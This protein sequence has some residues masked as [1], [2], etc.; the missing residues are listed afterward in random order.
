[1]LRGKSERV[2]TSLLGASRERGCCMH[3][4]YLFPACNLICNF[5]V[6][7]LCLLGTFIYWFW[8]FFFSPPPLQWC[9]GQRL[10]AA[11]SQLEHRTLVLDIAGE[12]DRPAW[13]PWSSWGSRR[14]AQVISPLGLQRCSVYWVKDGSWLCRCLVV[15]PEPG[16]SW[17]S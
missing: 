16:G 5:P 1:M 6:V 2:G 9:Q 14:S 3:H 7:E 11:E 15:T 13:E 8:G 4:H 17:R 12:S 10:V